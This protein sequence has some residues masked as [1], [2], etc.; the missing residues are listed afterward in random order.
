MHRVQGL[1][2]GVY[3]IQ[4]IWWSVRRVRSSGKHRLLFFKIFM[5]SVYNAGLWK[6]KGIIFE[7]F[8]GYC[9]ECEVLKYT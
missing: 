7:D 5:A 1:E 3:K 9:V 2:K 6:T 4:T 8:H